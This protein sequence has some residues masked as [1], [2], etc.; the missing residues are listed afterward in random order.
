M[1]SRWLAAGNAAEL[2]IYQGGAH[3][4][5]LFPNKLAEQAEARMVAFLTRVSG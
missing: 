5:T 1:Y 4:F 2:A 3:G